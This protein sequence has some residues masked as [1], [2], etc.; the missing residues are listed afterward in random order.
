MPLNNITRPA[1]PYDSVKLPNYN[2]YNNLG[3]KPPTAAMIDGD[4]N[5]VIDNINIVIDGVNEL[6][7]GSIPG[8]ADIANAHKVLS[9]TGAALE[10][11]L[12]TDENIEPGGISAVSL[13]ENTITGG[14]NGKIGAAA[15]TSFNIAE[16]AVT[17]QKING[18]AITT[19]KITNGA[20]TISK[21]ANNAVTTA[22]INNNAV[23]TGKIA[24][25]AVTAAK[26]ASAVVTG[27]MMPI[28][29][30]IANASTLQIEQGFLPCDGRAVLR[31]TYPT[32]FAALGVTYGAGD[33]ATTF[34]LPDLRGRVMAAVMYYPNSANN[35]I[36]NYSTDS[37]AAPTIGSIGG[38]E[39]VTLTTN[40]MPTHS[41]QYLIYE[42]NCN[43]LT[44]GSYN[45]P[46]GVTSVG[47]SG[48]TGGGQ[49]H[50]NMPPFICIP[51]YIFAFYP[52]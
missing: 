25:D 29:T 48:V 9:T 24:D 23:T 18:G 52:I 41:H 39:S 33:G 20:V 36:T 32:L 12:L 46:I 38:S 6:E 49:R 51:H 5:S 3:N 2:R 21:I 11:R 17:E 8:S 45:V 10:W 31:A 15:I 40:E 14:D 16:N 4:L 13:L 7:V 50:H 22:K 27:V 43:V 47:T 1:I 44:G 35:N 28:G 34:N 19:G 37:G 26:I 30:I 42:N